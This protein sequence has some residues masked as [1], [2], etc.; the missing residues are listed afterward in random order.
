MR[1][2]TA[3]DASL[4]LTIL[5]AAFEEHRGR[6]DPPS[7]VH[8]ETIESIRAKLRTGYALVGVV[9]GVAAGCV[10]YAPRG[11]HVYLGRLAVLPSY[12]HRGLGR[13]LIEHVERRARALGVRR[14]QLGLRLVLTDL[15]AYYERLGYRF[16]RQGA[17]TGYAEPTYVVM[18]KDV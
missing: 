14:V 15:R 5:H 9:G 8:G 3:D 7:G 2:A 17:H 10:F 16:V 11:A 6:V 12:R 13:A 1:E 18:E 4:I